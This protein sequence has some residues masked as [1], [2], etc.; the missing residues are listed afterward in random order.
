MEDPELQEIVRD[1]SQERDV[2]GVIIHGSSAHGKGDELSDVDVLV[3]AASGPTIHESHLKYSRPIDVYMAAMPKLSVKLHA[4][5][6]LNNNFV[7][8]ALVSGNIKFDV[9]GSVASLQ[10]EA[11]K[12]WAKG[13]QQMS[14]TEYGRAE[15]TLHR[16]LA[17]AEKWTLR[18]AA[19]DESRILAG[20]RRTQVMVQA[21]YLYHRVR[22]L[23][24]SGLP[25][26]LQLMKDHHRGA[27]DL[28]TRYIETIEENE[29]LMLVR[30]MVNMVFQS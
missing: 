16:M 9:N 21:I 4:V 11:R 3:V 29:Q 2:I 8:N 1:I 25:Q 5:D 10:A 17:S 26:T 18:S 7:L 24:T 19:S 13:P 22:R 6:P 14:L 12:L 20:F 15:A 28:W 30:S 27:Y 23:W